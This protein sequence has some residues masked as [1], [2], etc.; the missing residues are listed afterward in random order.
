MSTLSSKLRSR[1]QFGFAQMQPGRLSSWP[2]VSLPNGS[3][4][5]GSVYFRM[6]LDH[7]SMPRASR[8]ETR[9]GPT[10]RGCK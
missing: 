8:S 9:G 10:R 4:M 6:L 1:W 2:T 5:S 3:P 7:P